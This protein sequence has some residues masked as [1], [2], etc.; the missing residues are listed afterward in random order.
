MG[1][2]KTHRCWSNLPIFERVRFHMLAFLWLNSGILHVS[3]KV[4]MHRKAT[5]YWHDLLYHII[6]RCY[7]HVWF[8][9]YANQLFFS[10]NLTYWFMMKMKRSEYL[11]FRL[12]FKD[13]CEPLVTCWHSLCESSQIVILRKSEREKYKDWRLIRF[14]CFF[15]FLDAK[16]ATLEPVMSVCSALFLSLFFNVF[17][18]FH[19]RPKEAVP[20]G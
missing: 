13:C 14:L 5:Y 11:L 2:G 20:D 16:H 19:C 4:L 3:R 10:G 6:C 12:H 7:V 15:F 1:L 18:L 17:N 8:A 9:C